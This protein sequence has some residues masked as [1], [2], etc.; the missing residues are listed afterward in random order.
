MARNGSAAASTAHHRQPIP[1]D[2]MHPLQTCEDITIEGLFH[3]LFTGSIYGLIISRYTIKARF[4]NN[5]N[6]PQQLSFYQRIVKPTA[7]MT[8]SSSLLFGSVLS[9]YN[10]TSCRLKLYRHKYDVL[11]SAVGGVVAGAAI[12][13]PNL[14]VN[15]GYKYQHNWKQLG[16]NAAGVGLIGCLLYYISSY[17]NPLLQAP[18]G[19]SNTYNAAAEKHRLN[20]KLAI[21]E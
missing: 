3:G 15:R 16:L 14:I 4:M 5:N 13:A 2:P 20:K 11:N 18:L 19:S 8:V 12:S 17:F 7:T 21:V 10:Y 6:L 9:I 1:N